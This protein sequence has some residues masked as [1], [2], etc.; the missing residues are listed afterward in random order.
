MFSPGDGRNRGPESIASAGEGLN[1]TGS[2]RDIVLVS[3]A[4]DA[5]LNGLPDLD[6]Q[7]LGRG[8]AGES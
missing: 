5:Q 2:W 8:P 6:V 3:P 7:N 1:W 4:S